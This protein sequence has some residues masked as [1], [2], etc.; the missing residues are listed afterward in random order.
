MVTIGDQ[1]QSLLYGKERPNKI[2]IEYLYLTFTVLNLKPSSGQKHVKVL[3]LK[4]YQTK[5]EKQ[6]DLA[7]L[8]AKQIE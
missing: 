4:L 2:K 8:I 3:C 1:L 7:L 5:S 6:V